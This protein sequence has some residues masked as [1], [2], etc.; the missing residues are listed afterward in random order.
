M[1]FYLRYRKLY[2]KVPKTSITRFHFDTS[3]SFKYLVD[4]LNGWLNFFIQ[5][6]VERLDLNVSS[7]CL[8]QFILNASSLPV[9]KLSAMNLENLS[10]SNFPSLKVL[11]FN[12]V[13]RN[14]KSLQNVI[15]G[16]PVIE[17]FFSFI[18]SCSSLAGNS[19]LLLVDSS[20]CL[21]LLKL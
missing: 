21:Y 20:C 11:S 7:Y 5:R 3:Y 2:K 1:S 6:N 8:P 13:E 16:C 12:N 4:R 19:Y 10:L 14:A 15:S 17:D 9:L 18:F